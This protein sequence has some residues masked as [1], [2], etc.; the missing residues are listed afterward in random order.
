MV[1]IDVYFDKI[2]A[3]MMGEPYQNRLKM[4]LDKVKRGEKIETSKDIKDYAPEEVKAALLD[5][6]D[7]KCAFCECDVSM[8][9]PF[10]TEHFR[11]KYQ[12]CWLA[13]EWSNFVL[14]CKR[15]NTNK[16]IKFKINGEKAKMP[17][18]DFHKNLDAFLAQCHISELEDE[19]CLFLHPALHEPDE[20]LE[21]QENGLVFAKNGSSKGEYSINNYK[22][23]RDAVLVGNLVSERKRIVEK[24]RLRVE[25]AMMSY[26]KYGNEKELYD[27]IKDV[28]VDLFVSIHLKRP[29]AAVRIAC[30]RNFQTFFIDKFTGMQAIILNEVYAKVKQDFDSD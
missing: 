14:A 22:L 23:N 16:S 12:Y 5:A 9:A 25:R 18:I 13:Y 11:P 7:N 3:L 19:D 28:H 15:C 6:F 20:H 29:F 27:Q 30:I 1:K 24:M 2:P 21:F 4:L 8:G 10:D 17:D 26:L